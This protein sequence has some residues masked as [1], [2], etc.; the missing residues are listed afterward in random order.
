MTGDPTIGGSPEAVRV[1]RIAAMT[2]GNDS[3]D[4][5]R[6]IQR[7]TAVQNRNMQLGAGIG[8]GAGTVVGTVLGVL[9]D[10]SG[11][12]GASFGLPVGIAIGL[13]IGT[14]IDTLDA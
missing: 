4:V 2:H 1:P 12:M 7:A 14:S 9:L 5:T 6:S 13:A 8:A 3:D 11:A 10:G